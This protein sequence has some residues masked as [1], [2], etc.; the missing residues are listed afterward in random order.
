[1]FTVK[2]TVNTM[3]ETNNLHARDGKSKTYLLNKDSKEN[4]TLLLSL[5][6]APPPN[7]NNAYTFLL[8]TLSLFSWQRKVIAWTRTFKI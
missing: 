4:H 7:L 6:L 8:L 5:G 2:N 3:L 1:M